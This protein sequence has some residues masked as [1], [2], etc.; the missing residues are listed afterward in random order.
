MDHNLQ[1]LRYEDVEAKPD[2]S[3]EVSRVVRMFA[4]K[5]A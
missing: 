1:I 3:K 5:P 4:R 2:W